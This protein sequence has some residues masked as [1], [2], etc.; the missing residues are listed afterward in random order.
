MST[1]LK[2]NLQEID[3][4]TPG[5]SDVTITNNQRKSILKSAVHNGEPSK[6]KSLLTDENHRKS[7]KS[8]SWLKYILLV[9]WIYKGYI[10]KWCFQRKIDQLRIIK[11]IFE[12]FKEN[13]F[14]LVN[15]EN[16][17]IIEASSVM[18]NKSKH[19]TKYEKFR[20]N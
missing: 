12:K 1:P 8:T 13:F 11:N 10:E 20:V 2:I 5:Y 3:H 7:L 17:Q 14:F 18:G 16:V 9:T 4:L 6:R 15:T 19:D